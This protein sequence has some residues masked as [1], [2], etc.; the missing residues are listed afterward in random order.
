MSENFVI[1]AD[2]GTT[3]TTIHR[4][5]AEGKFDSLSTAQHKQIYRK[6]GWVEHNPEEL[7]TQVRSEERRVGK[8]CRL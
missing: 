8:E 3:G 5:N 4:L 7:I 1:A 2:Q 6:P